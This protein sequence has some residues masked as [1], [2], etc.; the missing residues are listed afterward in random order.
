[1]PRRRVA[2]ASRP[3]ERRQEG[4]K[5]PAPPGRASPPSLPGM[6]AAVRAF[7]LAAGLD[8]DS[9]P[10]LRQT[11]ELTARAW[12]D[13][14]LDGYRATPA[15]VLAERM[16]AGGAAEG[17]L[18]NVLHLDFQSVCPH[19]LLP[20]GGVAHVAYVPGAH[21]VG[22]GQIARLLDC[23]GHRLV[24]QEDLARQVAQALVDELGAQGAAAVL[25]AE[26][27]CLTLRGGRRAGARIVVEAFAGSMGEREELRQRFLSAIERS[28]RC[29]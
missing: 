3:S 9:N 24:L 29:G 17:E 11:P 10:E 20:Y 21:V 25:D 23:L 16:P 22:F 19:H 27:A 15:Q 26:Q 1:M 28:E 4:R 2:L 12:A 6:Q 13:E 8:A 18:V 14:F 7:L 5:A